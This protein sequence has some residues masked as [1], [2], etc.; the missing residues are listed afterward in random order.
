L[1]SF[2]IYFVKGVIKHVFPALR[3]T[4]KENLA[5]SVFGLIKARNGKISEIA[6]EIPGAFKHK[7]RFKRLFRFLANWRVKPERLFNSWINWCFNAFIP[8]STRYVSIAIDWSTMRWSKD[9]LMMA[10]PFAGRA[11]PLVWRLLPSKEFIIDSRNRIEERLLSRLFNLLPKRVKPIILADRGFGRALFIKFL[12]NK[13]VLFVVRVKSEVIITT[14]KGKK[15]KLSNF[16]KKL[17]PEEPIWFKNISYRDDE[18]VNGINLVAVV[19]KGSD[20]PWF[21]VTNLKSSNSAISRY[22]ERFDIEEWFKDV[23]HP[24]GLEKIQTKNNKRIRRLIFI[25]AVAYGILMLIGT[26]ADRFTSWKDRLITNGG[27]TA[28]RIWFALKLIK[29]NML[30]TFFW[31]RVWVKARSP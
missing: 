6:R 19:A 15:I 13:G 25:S 29:H 7:H 18:V 27:I 2:N 5:L 12:L 8:N 3:K 16:T 14:S 31:R 1:F 17:V 20:D 10:V 28:S 23:K 21:L 9:L 26:L 24:L 4:Q 11:L 30:P 22:K